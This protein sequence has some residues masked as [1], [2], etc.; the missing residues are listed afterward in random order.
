MLMAACGGKAG[1]DKKEAEATVD[2]NKA[3]QSSTPAPSAA[4]S[5]DIA[6]EMTFVLSNQPD[7]LD[8]S[9]T[10]N[11]FAAPFLVNCFEGLVTYGPDG[12]IAP[13]NAKKWEGNDDLTVYTFHLR[14]G[15]KWSDGSP[16]TAQDY[17]YAAQHVCTPGTTAQ[18]LAMYTDYIVGA[19]EFYE[20]K[21]DAAAF[22]VK[23]ID[24][25]TLQYTLKAPCPYFPD[26]VSMWCFFPLKKDTIDA[27][28]DKW[29]QSP[30]SYVC[31][32]PFKIV[33]INNGESIVLAKNDNYWEADKVTLKKLTFRYILDQST[34]LTAY[35]NNEVQGIRSAPSGDLARLKAEN[36]GLKIVPSYGTVY[37]D[38][39]CAKAPYDNPLVRK[40]LAL[41]IDREQLIRNVVQL[42]ATPAYSW[43]AAGYKLD[44]KDVTEGRPNYDLKPT[45]DPEA[46]KA[47]LAEAGYADPASFPTLQ[48]SFYSD[49]TAKKVAEALAEMLK[50]NLGIKVEVTSAD[51]AVFYD[52]IQAGNYE[53]AA[54]GW[55]ADY[56]HPMS[57][58]PL[59][60]TDDVSNNCF[61]SN[62]DYDAIVDQLRTEQDP[63]KVAE[64]VRKADEVVSMEYPVL[65]LYYKS[66]TY[67]LHDNVE[68]VYMITNSNL[69]FKY[70]VVK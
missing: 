45:A 36:A 52:S 70:A 59:L 29:T 40:A 67:L 58:M 33:E 55:S 28:G 65:P 51:W 44:G 63:A 39:N 47:A 32:G 53:V 26:L 49:D 18:Y 3:G 15:L 56:V 27:N 64:L 37:Y 60:Y 6:Q 5:G 43:L 21:G 46:A 14:D 11:S 12:G 48:L 24:E 31:N 61:Y 66:N 1:T 4:P 20:G 50:T 19:Q 9:Y 41:A 62:K 10:N 8:P 69:Y 54:M 2:L 35:E 17:V 22:G 42:D 68:G 7:S 25:K 23:A 34:A 16:L 57:F 38:I 30:E 13:G